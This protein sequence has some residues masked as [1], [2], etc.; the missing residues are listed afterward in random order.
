MIS[1]LPADHLFAPFVRG[2]THTPGTGLGLSIAARASRTL[3]GDVQ[4][5]NR[6]GQGCV[7]T[8][9]FPSVPVTTAAE[10]WQREDMERRLRTTSPTSVKHGY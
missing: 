4:V 1:K 10:V 6:P 7:F 5:R 8:I 9:D 3:G 2:T